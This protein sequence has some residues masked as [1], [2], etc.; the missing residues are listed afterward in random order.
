MEHAFEV[1]APA[2]RPVRVLRVIDKLGHGDRL[3]GPGRMW[4]N[5]LNAF[6]GDRTDVIACV[7]R[8]TPRI[9]GQFE[10]H[11]VALRH[12]AHGRFSP[13]TVRTLCRLIREERIDVL[14]LHGFGAT[15]FGRIAARI[16]DIPA[17]THHHDMEFGPWYVRWID[18]CLAP[19]TARAIA[20]SESVA[21]ACRVRRHLPRE[22]TVVVPNAVHGRWVVPEDPARCRERRRALGI[23]LD[24]PLVGSVTRFHP[25]KDLPVLLQAVHRMRT[26]PPPHLLLVGDGPERGAL[27]RTMRALGISERTHCV[28][29]QDDARPYVALM[30]VMVVCSLHEGFSTALLEAMAL[31]RPVVATAT[32]GMS[33]LVRD[34]RNGVLVPPHDPQRLADAVQRLLEEPALA[35]RLAAQARRDAVSFTVSA[36]VERIENLYLQVHRAP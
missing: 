11:G 22:R 2:S 19:V 27:E 32:G 9:R 13:W 12:L 17:I 30:D 14:H 15:T 25:V 16:M 34:G 7:L 18:R 28:G 33:E 21:E 36:H 6:H 24:A 29:F 4:L 26:T 1:A 10:E 8:T 31:G 5:T 35:S 20:V 23:P 3:H